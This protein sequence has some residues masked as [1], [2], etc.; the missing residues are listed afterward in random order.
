MKLYVFAILDEKANVFGTPWTMNTKAEAIRAFSDLAENKETTVGRHPGDF[1]LYELGSFDNET[2][3]LRET[4][5][6]A[7]LGFASEYL[8]T[9]AILP[10]PKG[11]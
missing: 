2:G 5:P 10:N 4:S 3:Q 7:K 6:L 1:Q 11:K 9:G 8:K